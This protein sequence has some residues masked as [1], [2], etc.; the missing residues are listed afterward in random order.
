MLNDNYS[1]ITQNISSAKNIAIFTH[2]LP[3]GDAIGSSCALA[4]LLQNMGK[5]AKVYLQSPIPDEYKYFFIDDIVA[6]EV[7][8]NLD[9]VIIADCADVDRLG[10]F[11]RFVKNAEKSIA[12]DHHK[13]FVPFAKHNFVS[14]TSSSASEFLCDIFNNQSLSLDK[15]IAEF[16]YLGILRDTGGFMHDC[17]SSHT[18]RVVADLLDYNIDAENINRHFMMRTTYKTTMLL[19]VVLNNLSFYNFGKIAISNISKAELDSY[20]AL[21]EDT[22]GIIGHI[23]SIDTVEIAVLITEASPNVHKVSIRS[24]YNLDASDVAKDFGGGGHKKASGCQMYG[25]IQKI[26]NALVKAI[27]RRQ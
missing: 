23:L 8:K 13:T 27:Q 6:Y 18:L 11:S 22:G 10:N 26:T 16:L 4:C 17:T 24:K 15:R 25:Q 9:L 20:N 12:I 7:P 19:K 1:V 3:D 21:V 14:E 5:N 2:I